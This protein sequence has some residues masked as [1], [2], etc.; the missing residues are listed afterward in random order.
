MILAVLLALG[1]IGVAVQSVGAKLSNLWMT[2]SDFTALS[3]LC[4]KTWGKNF[5][6]WLGYYRTLVHQSWISYS[7]L[8]IVFGSISLAF[9]SRT[10]C[11]MRVVS[12]E[13]FGYSILRS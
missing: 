4:V 3:S 8:F 5:N 12:T 6:R 9:Y 7:L 13:N 1:A 11:M 2:A 10:E